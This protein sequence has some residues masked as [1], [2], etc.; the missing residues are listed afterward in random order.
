MRLPVLSWILCVLAL[1]GLLAWLGSDIAPVTKGG[2]TAN[3]PLIG[4]DFSLTDGAGKTVTNHDFQGR[5]MLVYFGFTHCPDICPTSLLL[6]QN[7]LKQ[8]GDKGKKVVPIFITLDPERDTPETVG[9]YVAHFGPELVGLS[10]T[11]EQI[12]QVADAYKIYYRKVEDKD[13]A[14]GY[15]ID[16]SG[17]MYLMGPDGKYVTHFPHTIAE[18]S[19][20]DGLAA[21]IK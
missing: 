14:M 4:G 20:T 2:E 9:Q 19:L 18:Q 5:Y 3:A 17:F 8:L 16:H 15:V 13:S 21:A 1:L 7:A 11:P 10:G 12:K 6:I